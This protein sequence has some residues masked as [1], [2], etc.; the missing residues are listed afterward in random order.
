MFRPSRISSTWLC[1]A[2]QRQS[3]AISC[4]Q[5]AAAASELKVLP[6]RTNI[7]FFVIAPVVPSFFV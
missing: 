3:H 7:L 1:W 6:M 4:S 2:L 5:S